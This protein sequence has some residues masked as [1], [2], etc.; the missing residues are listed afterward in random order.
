MIE[1]DQLGERG[2]CVLDSFL[3]S[4]N[5]AQIL[6]W[7][8][9]AWDRGEFRDGRVGKGEAQRES[10]IRTDYIRWIRETETSEVL[11]HAA[12]FAAMIQLREQLRE[13][14]FLPLKSH[15]FHATVYP[16]GAFYRKHVDVFRGEQSTRLMS[17]IYYLNADWKPEDGG[18]LRIYPQD[19]TGFVDIYPAF[20]RLVV[21]QSRKIPHEVLAP[22]R[23]RFALTGW[24]RSDLPLIP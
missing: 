8:Q 21:F 5:A 13:E 17:C 3:P 23:P 9:A 12:F 24:L 19:E 10:Q 14:A 20:N 4:E 2:W 16:P 22:T 6:K 18:A 15:E 7:E 11:P 1:V